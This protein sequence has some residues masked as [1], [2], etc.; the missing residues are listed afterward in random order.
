MA[1]ENTKLSN[2][3]GAPF[4]D[5]VLR[6]LA[7]RA[8]NSSTGGSPWGPRTDEQVLYLANKLAWVRVVSSVDIAFPEGSKETV[9]NYIQKLGIADSGTYS[10]GNSLASN[11]VLQAGTSKYNF[12]SAAGP[13]GSFLREGFGPDGAYGL[14][15]TQELG[16]RP[17]PGLTS[18]TIE[19]VGRL[20]SLRTAT[21]NFK[22]WNMNQ[23][24]TIEA[25]YFRLGY[26]MLIEWGHVQYFQNSDA[27]DGVST[28]KGVFVPKPAPGINNPFAEGLRKETIQQEIEKQKFKSSGN[29]DGML[30]IVANFNWSLNREGGYDCT[31]K[32]VGLGA[33]MDSIRIN[34]SYKLPNSTIKRLK[35]AQDGLLEKYKRDLA[36]KRKR[37]KDLADLR[38]QIQD[39][40]AAGGAGGGSQI[41]FDAQPKT[42]A[43]LYQRAVK[44]N[45]YKGTQTDFENDPQYQ[46][47]GILG[48]NTV[49]GFRGSFL[50]ISKPPS[51]LPDESLAIAKEKYDGAYYLRGSTLYRLPLTGGANVTLLI[52]KAQ[53]RG[54]EQQSVEAFI[55]KAVERKILG[56]GVT[57]AELAVGL[58]KKSDGTPDIVSNE[59]LVQF[60]DWRSAR[61]NKPSFD[62]ALDYPLDDIIKQRIQTS[63]DVRDEIP[64]SFRLINTDFRYRLNIEDAEFWGLTSDEEVYFNLGVK[65]ESPDP[66]VPITRREIL[67]ALDK[68]IKDGAKAQLTKVTKP[69]SKGI[70]T[71][72][73]TFTVPVTKTVN[74]T[75]GAQTITKNLIWTFE[76]NNLIFF[77]TSDALPPP[78]K[79]ASPGTGTTVT[80]S[81]DSEEPKLE[82]QQAN[83]YEGYESAL[84]AM[85]TVVQYLSQENSTKRGD[86]SIYSLIN[87]TKPFYADGCFEKLLDLQG[88]TPTPPTEFSLLE[89]AAKGFSSELMADNSKF[90]KIPYIGGSISKPDFSSLCQSVTIKYKQV[91]ETGV[92]YAGDYQVYIPLGYLL[93]FINNMCLFYD[94][95]QATTSTNPPAKGSEKR[96]YVY[97]DYNPETNF[98]LTSP[99]QFSID[100]NVCM[101]PAQL[102]QSQYLELYPTEIA[103]VLPN[104]FNPGG[105]G[106]NNVSAA[107]GKA[108]LKF[109]TDKDYQGKTMN[110]LVCTNYLLRILREYSTSDPQHAVALQPF[111]ER[112]MRDIN[113]ALGNVNAFRV[114][115]RDDT[116]TIQIQDD[117]YVPPLGSETSIMVKKDF[118]TKL[119]DAIV[120]SGE[121]PIFSVKVPTVS[122]DLRQVSLPNL[123]IARQMQLKT[124]MSTKLASMIAISAQAATGSVNA[125]DHTSLSWL[126]KN[127]RDRYKP[128]IQDADN[129]SNGTNT[130]PPAG[131]NKTKTQAKPSSDQ[132]QATNFNTHVKSV[133]NDLQISQDAIEPSKNY[134]IERMSKV[135]SRDET[136]LA[137]PFIP[138][139]LELTLDGISGIIMGNAFN[140]PP[141]RL[142]LSMRGSN[143]DDAGLPLVGFIVTGLT[144]RIQNNEWTTTIKGQM[145]KL[146]EQSGLGAKPAELPSQVIQS[147]DNAPAVPV[148]IKNGI[149]VKSDAG[150]IDIFGDKCDRAK[151]GPYSGASQILEGSINSSNFSEYATRKLGLRTPYEFKKANNGN[152]NINLAALGLTPLAQADIVDLTQLNRFNLGV[153]QNP[154]KWIVMHHTAGDAQFRG[155]GPGQGASGTIRTFYCRGFPA[156]YV[157]DGNGT[158]YRFMPDG[159]LGY[160]VGATGWNTMSIGVEIQG[161]NNNAVKKNQNQIDAAIRLAH[162]LGFNWQQVVGHGGIQTKTATTAD[163]AD[164][165][166]FTV[167]NRL[168]PKYLAKFD[169]DLLASVD[170]N[171]YWTRK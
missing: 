55:A 33:V 130:T 99:Q 82:A 12:N 153:I 20:G 110:I 139:E 169:P 50:S 61:Q 10:G 111:L 150:K 109:K 38:K 27:T 142:P 64:N 92:S 16:Y 86:I 78:P 158:I 14:G 101:I 35:N 1:T 59:L 77:N 37:E 170:P 70:A 156:Q 118:Y 133:Y 15:G 66:I 75:A 49:K 40:K 83:P 58:N 91:N 62:F 141:D 21:I 152:S 29:Y 114:A 2:V 171:T 108:N 76:T 145:I 32:L 22:V 105:N 69:N 103:K 148:E 71:Y 151:W 154:P 42:Y 79:P 160:H 87:E 167:T 162:F 28:N 97:I 13:T 94:S 25:L 93:G 4:S 5:Y 57:L 31:L 6:Q 149:A 124:V 155:S 73:G 137:A 43:E 88:T 125:T 51:D 168:N 163:K 164:D 100:P 104:P 159:A 120:T 107:L 129:G 45:A 81:D 9:S 63:Y 96:P 138:A 90:D 166:G 41:D 119:K 140:I 84:H 115:Y 89:Y 126:N 56:S 113:K 121:L 24:N 11:W 44:Y 47:R 53:S 17:M 135:K 3:I 98:C 132:E 128:Y 52:S 26:S 74:V 95:K 8:S 161:A 157:I 23:L 30:G 19:T 143:K 116:N 123:G 117:Q 68:W 36:E 80:T 65:V 85:L 46:A 48:F 165:E 122:G 72:S 144:N 67:Q 106:T 34:Q 136:T 147:S 127:F 54:I 131:K 60:F 102:N 39:L 7:I 112:V 146:R 134:Y 18:V